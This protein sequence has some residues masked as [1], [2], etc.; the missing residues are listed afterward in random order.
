MMLRA[1]I[2]NLF[3]V[4]MQQRVVP[5][6]SVQ[7]CGTIYCQMGKAS[8]LTGACNHDL[9]SRRFLISNAASAVERELFEVRVYGS[10][11]PSLASSCESQPSRT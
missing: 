5:D 1:D 4:I 11:A 8:I 6:I 10:C 7:M 3:L 9:P 2:V